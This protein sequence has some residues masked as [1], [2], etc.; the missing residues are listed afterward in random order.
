MCFFKNE[1]TEI[2]FVERFFITKYSKDC[3][4]SHSIIKKIMFYFEKYGSV[5][6]FRNRHKKE[7]TGQKSR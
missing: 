2:F 6:N 7:I 1:L 4:L 5:A 3:T